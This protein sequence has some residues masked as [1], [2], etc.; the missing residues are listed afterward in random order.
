[1]ACAVA[2]AAGPEEAPATPAPAPVVATT[3]APLIEPA[4]PPPRPRRFFVHLN[5]SFNLYTYV[6][7]KGAL[8]A[9]NLTPDKRIGL[10]QQLGFGYAVLPYL[11]VALTLQLGESATGVAPG[12]SHFTTFGFIPWVIF[13]THGFSAGI[14]PLLWA[15]AYGKNQFETGIFFST[16]YVWKLPHGF[17]LGV[18][19]QTPLT[20]YQRLTFQVS[21]V[22]TAT[23]TF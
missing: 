10:G 15:R 11:R 13:T 4:P 3:P 14:G 9:Q 2:R 6:G 7:D 22:V 23:Y 20:L 18:A 19:V 1:M 21:P 5:E 17:G 8:P 16:G 12:G